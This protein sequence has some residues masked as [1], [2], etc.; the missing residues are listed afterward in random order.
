[1]HILLTNN[2]YLIT[3]KYQ[4]SVH[5]C[6]VSKLIWSTICLGCFIIGCVL[7]A[8]EIALP[9]LIIKTINYF[10]P[11]IACYFIMLVLI[12]ILEKVIIFKSLHDAQK[13]VL[14]FDCLLRMHTISFLFSCLFIIDT[15]INSNMC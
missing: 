5:Q 8:V 7:F 15:K 13:V 3:N 2:Y 12:V 6:L 1:M 4:L 10:W 14:T 11:L 9:C